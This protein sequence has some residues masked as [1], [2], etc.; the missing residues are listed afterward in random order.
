M[1][2]TKPIVGRITASC[3]A[4]IIAGCAMTKPENGSSV[5]HSEIDSQVR[6]FVNSTPEAYAAMETLPKDE[7]LQMLNMLQFND[8]A[9]YEEGSDYAQKGW[10]GEEAFAEYTRRAGPIARRLGAKPIY[11]GAPQLTLIGPEY[12]KWDA[13][14]IFEYADVESFLALI[15]NPDYK[16][17]AFHRSAAVENS[18]LIRMAPPPKL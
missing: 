4:L 13:V 9:N 1:T 17:H 18:R 7:P 14:F 5:I 8:V 2:L 12:E 11:I 15:N 16:K 6:V 10:T 3:L